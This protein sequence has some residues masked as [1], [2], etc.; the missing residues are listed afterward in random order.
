[1]W[2]AAPRADP[3]GKP[4]KPEVV[5]YDKDHAEIKWTPSKDDGGS[6]IQKYIVEKRPKGGN[7]EKASSR[8]L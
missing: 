2:I 1:M 4:G 5:D 7:W 8:L 6:P 3:P